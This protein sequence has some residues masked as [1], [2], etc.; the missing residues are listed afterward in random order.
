MEEGELGEGELGEGELGEGSWERGV[1]RG[2][3]GDRY[4][5]ASLVNQ[6]RGR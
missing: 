6:F 4:E 1:G 2:E 5:P 3:L